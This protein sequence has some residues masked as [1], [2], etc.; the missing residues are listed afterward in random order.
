[1]TTPEARETQ[2]RT[3]AEAAEQAWHA[4]WIKKG[5][6][7]DG[8]LAVVA[9]IRAL[10]L[11]EVEACDCPISS[12]GA[13]KLHHLNCRFAP[14]DT[15]TADAERRVIEAA[16]WDEAASYVCESY[17]QHRSDGL[18]TSNHGAHLVAHFQ[19]RANAL[20]AAQA[21]PA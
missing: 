12:I 13:L 5:T 11:P 1:M 18:P 14:P 6:T 3:A 20:R 7:R 8:W 2:N 19:R 15:R 4:N 10:P 16:I 17:A 21:P 9:A